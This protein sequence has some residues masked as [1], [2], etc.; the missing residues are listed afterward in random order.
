MKNLMAYKGSF[1]SWEGFDRNC[2]NSLRQVIIPEFPW[3]WPLEDSRVL[4]GVPW[5]LA[6]QFWAHLILQTL[7]PTAS[8]FSSIMAS[9][10]SSFTL[11]SL[12]SPSPFTLLLLGQFQE[13]YTSVS[14]CSCCQSITT[15]SLAVVLPFF[16]LQPFLLYVFF[17]FPVS[18]IS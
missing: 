7:T 15:S 14:F 2:L 12:A 11:S 17:L 13:L 4:D 18:I 16:S 1:S 6:V 9:F 3:V 5:A 10:L 8:W